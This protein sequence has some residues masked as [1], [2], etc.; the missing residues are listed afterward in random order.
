MDKGTTN[1]YS[2]LNLSFAYL[3]TMFKGWKNKDF[4]GIGFGMNNVFGREQVF[5]YNYS[6]NGLHK[7]PITQ[8]AVR[9][10]YAGLFMS[11]GIDRRDDFI[12][13]NL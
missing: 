1:T 10:W 8:V 7:L 5:G 9:T 6:Y 2:G 13:E 4:S 11:F 12:N 3:F